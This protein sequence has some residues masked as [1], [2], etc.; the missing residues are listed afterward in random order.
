MVALTVAA[1]NI[2][3]NRGCC[4]AARRADRLVHLPLIDEG[5]GDE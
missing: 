5:H 3:T 4:R 2:D 1:E